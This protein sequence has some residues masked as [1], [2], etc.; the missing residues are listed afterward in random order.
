MIEVRNVCSTSPFAFS[1][2]SVS[3]GDYNLTAVATDDVG[4]SATSDVVT[5]H[6]VADD[7]S[8]DPLTIDAID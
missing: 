3:A 2:N 5:V 1:W 8:A 7:L 4:A 6:V